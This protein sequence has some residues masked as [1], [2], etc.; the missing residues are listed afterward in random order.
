MGKGGLWVFMHLVT[1]QCNV[2][3]WFSVVYT[4]VSIVLVH[5]LFVSIKKNNKNILDQLQI[6]YRMLQRG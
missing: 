6:V 2:H 5:V 3:A 4:V 1:V